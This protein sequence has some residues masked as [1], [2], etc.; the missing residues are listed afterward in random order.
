MDDGNTPCRV[1]DVTG[2]PWPD[3]CI[4]VAPVDDRIRLGMS[5]EWTKFPRLDDG[6]C[7]LEI[8][9]EEMGGIAGELRA[10]ATELSSVEKGTCALEPGPAVDDATITEFPAEIT[11]LPTL[12]N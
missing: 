1:V 12:S 11:E 10:E 9:V 7:V 4:C 8:N 5:A 2:F 6:T 3:D